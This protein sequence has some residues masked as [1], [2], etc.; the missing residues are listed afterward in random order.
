[1]K[2]KTYIHKISTR[3]QKSKKDIYMFFN[4]Y[5]LIVFTSFQNVSDSLILRLYNCLYSSKFRI[6]GTKKTKKKREK[7]FFNINYK[8]RLI[9]NFNSF[10]LIYHSWYVIF[11]LVVLIEPH[12]LDFDVSFQ[13]WWKSMIIYSVY[14]IVLISISDC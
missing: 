7:H 12:W 8:L 14:D 9:I 10:Q 4:F 11:Y 6:W 13:T 2:Y 1:M 5:I 3:Q